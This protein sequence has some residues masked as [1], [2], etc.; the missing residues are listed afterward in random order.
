MIRSRSI[1]SQLVLL[2]L[3]GTACGPLGPFSGGALRGSVH[4]GAAPSW[5]T[6]AAL[7]TVQLE[8]SPGDPHSVNIWCAESGGRLYIATSLILGAD[9]PLDR[10][11]VQHVEEDPRVRLR[12]DGVI[13]LLEAKRVEAEPERTSAW[14]SLVE[15]YEVEVD[16]HARGAWIYRLDPR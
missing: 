4:D 6:V 16:D 15:K 8:T 11:W 9:E 3:L 2:V 7:E 10:A 5:Q 13:Y 14:N 12:A 1:V